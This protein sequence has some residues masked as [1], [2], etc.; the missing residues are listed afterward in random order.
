MDAD[1]VD[2]RVELESGD[3]QAGRNVSGAD[4]GW[5]TVPDRHADRGS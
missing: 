2:R 4:P 5:R 3:A 1:G